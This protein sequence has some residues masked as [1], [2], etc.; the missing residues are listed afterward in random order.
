MMETSNETRNAARKNVVRVVSA[1]CFAAWLV[2]GSV[3]AFGGGAGEARELKEVVIGFQTIPN[4]EIVAKAF[5]RHEETFGLPVRWVQFSSGSELNAAVA[6][7]DVHL[8]LGGSSTTV[9][10]IAQGVPAEVIWIYNI[11]GDNEA[12][13]VREDSDIDRVEDLVGKRAA[14][15]FGATTH[16]HLLVALGLHDVAPGGL[17]I[18]D[19]AP[20]DMLA[21]WQRGDIDAGFVWEPT[22]AAM[23]DSGGRV[24]ISSRE[25]ADEGFL[26]G[27]IGIAHTRFASQHPEIVVQYLKNQIEAVE[28]IRNDPEAAAEAIAQEF[29]LSSEEALRQMQSLV[30]L[31][32]R[33]Q[34][35]AEYLGTPE[36]PGDLAGVFRETA[37]FL[38]E[39]GILR[40]APELPVFQAAIN[41][42]YLQQ[43]V[44]R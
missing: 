15:P 25:I 41:S 28:V 6:A 11:I 22:L 12:L 4:G 10:A 5:G 26:T 1:A 30:F 37:V 34:L 13:V 14:A 24:L 39:Q 20:S 18:M 23:L 43:A 7:G 2:V 17:T 21:A 33:E 29:D 19:L 8:G 27:D 35:Q 31:D 9:S 42:H 36:A 3:A 32:G 40:E 16:Y 44:E 38:Q